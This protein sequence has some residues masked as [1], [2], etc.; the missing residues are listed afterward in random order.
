MIGANIDISIVHDEFNRLLRAASNTQPVLKAIGEKAVEFTKTRFAVSQDPY[1]A[2]WK[3]NAAVTLDLHL[4]RSKA[5]FTKSGQI[6]AKG[7]RALAGKNPLIGETRALSTNIFSRVA[8][9]AVEVGSPL[10]YAAIHQFGGKA[11]RVRKVSI[12]ARPFL[13]DPQRG[14]P[15]PLND[16]I[17]AVLIEHLHRAKS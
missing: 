3:P 16:D 2:A 17:I 5:N 1:G 13:P 4:S 10:I 11:G 7:Q 9:E 8:G 14:L 12:P 6:S 15:A